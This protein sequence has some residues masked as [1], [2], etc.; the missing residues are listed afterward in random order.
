MIVLDA[1]AVIVSLLREIGHEGVDLLLETQPCAISAVNVSEVHARLLRAGSSNTRSRHMID[2]IEFQLLPIDR[3]I[4]ELA[5]ILRAP[6]VGSGLGIA[7]RICIATGMLH[8]APIYTADTT[9]AKLDLPEADIQLV[10]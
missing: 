1:S 2:A 3:A 8:D 7:D 4:A 5:A 9:W 6:T 10:R